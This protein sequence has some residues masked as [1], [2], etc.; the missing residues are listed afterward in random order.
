[1][2][3]N[4]WKTL[5]NIKVKCHWKLKIRV[6]L[7]NR[8]RSA[9][10]ALRGIIFAVYTVKRQIVSYYAKV[11]DIK[12]M[13]CKLAAN[14][15]LYNLDRFHLSILHVQVRL[16]E[17][18]LSNVCWKYCSDLALFWLSLKKYVVWP[19]FKRIWLFLKVIWLCACTHWAEAY[20]PCLRAV[21][22]RIDSCRVDR[23]VNIC[24]RSA[25]HVDVF[26]S[27]SKKV[28]LWSF[29]NISKKDKLF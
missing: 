27:S 1:V 4:I 21:I 29:I 2:V 23:E 24:I 20:Q 19:N 26:T 11:G 17:I 5:K 28:N 6:A 3:S 15:I 13:C 9:V 18:N 12:I 16:V 7:P 25:S 8:V 14:I 10:W 22:Q